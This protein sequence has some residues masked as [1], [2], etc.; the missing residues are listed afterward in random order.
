MTRNEI[1]KASLMLRERLNI[2]GPVSKDLLTDVLESRYDAYIFYYPLGKEKI[3]GFAVKKKEIKFILINSSLVLGRQ[4]FTLAHELGHFEL[5][6][7]SATHDVDIRNKSNEREADVFAASFLMPENDCRSNFEKVAVFT[8]YDILRFSQYF[9]VSFESAKN[10]VFGNRLKCD[11]TK[12]VHGIINNARAIFPGQNFDEELYKN[13]N[14]I[15]YP[16]MKFTDKLKRA[17][18]GADISYG[19]LV[20]ICKERDLDTLKLL[21]LWGAGN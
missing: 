1:E 21:E 16:M 11:E 7:N 19:K 6:G 12:S 13:T 14:Q 2:Q 20:E 18:T 15:R 5:H 10:R 3:S 8:N 4:N 17:Y 9:R